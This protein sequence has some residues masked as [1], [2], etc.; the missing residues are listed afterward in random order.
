L[1]TQNTTNNIN[2]DQQLLIDQIIESIQDVK[3][4]GI[5]K[6]DLRGL[7]GPADFFI[8]CQGDS[9]TQV[10]AIGNNI[11]RDVKQKLKSLPVGFE[12][13]MEPTWVLVDYFDVVVH[14]FYPETREFYDIETLWGDGVIENIEDLD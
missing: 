2:E 3:G 4:K 9:T 8:I 10:A 11:K 1:T 14:V 12:A 6:I 5:T 13:P 7:D